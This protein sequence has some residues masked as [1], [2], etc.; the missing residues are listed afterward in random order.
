MNHTGP[1]T[2][3]RFSEGQIHILCYHYISKQEESYCGT[4][5]KQL[6]QGLKIS[7]YNC[8]CYGRP[9]GVNSYSF[10]SPLHCTAQI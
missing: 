6:K 1:Q 3:F 7:T 5:T 2:A 4:E 10:D 8:F 9:G